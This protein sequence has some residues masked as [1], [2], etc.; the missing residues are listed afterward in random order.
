MAGELH[1]SLPSV[2]V[3]RGDGNRLPLAT[4]SADLIT[5]AQPWHWTDPAQALPEALRALRPGGAPALWWNVS[6]DSVR[7]ISGQD[8]RLRWH[9]GAEN[10]AYGTPAGAGSR[11]PSEAPG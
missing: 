11:N 9:L 7:W 1:R 3:V 10:G 2:P 6:D 5:Y 8:T 4:G